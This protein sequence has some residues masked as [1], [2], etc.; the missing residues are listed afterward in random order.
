MANG[1][2]QIEQELKELK[3]LLEKKNGN[4]S[5]SSHLK[6][7]QAFVYIIVIVIGMGVSWGVSTS[8][9]SAMQ[10]TVT[11][12]QQQLNQ[13]EQDLRELQLKQAGDDKVLETL[14][15]DITEIKSDLKKLINRGQ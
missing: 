13:T 8:K 15:K 12:M 10:A 4:G 14:Q 7:I 11:S 6:G 5:W 3:C 9:L 1:I 2:D